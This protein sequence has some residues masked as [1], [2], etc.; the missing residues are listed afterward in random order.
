[1]GAVANFV[2]Q[3]HQLHATTP[4]HLKTIQPSNNYVRVHNETSTMESP[5]H[6]STRN[7]SSHLYL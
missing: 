7:D 1:M 3:P 5:Q 6:R 4:H 2:D